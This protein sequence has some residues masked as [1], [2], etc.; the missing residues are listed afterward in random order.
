MRTILALLCAVVFASATQAASYTTPSYTLSA[1]VAANPLTYSAVT[2]T[3]VHN[4]AAPT[5]VAAGGQMTDPDF[6]T[7]FLRLTS[8]TS[9]AAAGGS[10]FMPNEGTGWTPTT[11]TNDTAILF[12]SSNGWWYVQ[13][14]T[15]NGSAMALNGACVQIPI[16]SGNTALYFSATNP[17]LIFGIHGNYFASY[18]WQTGV[19]TN[20]FDVATIP[21]F[22]VHSLYL[23][24]CDHADTWC[25]TS[26]NSQNAGT[27][28]AFY[29]LKT[30]ATAVYDL[31]AATVQLGSAT[32]VSMIGWTATDGA[33]CGIHET[34]PDPTGAYWDITLDT[35]TN[36]KSPWDSLFL[37]VGT[38]NM[39]YIK[40]TDEVGGHEAMGVGPVYVNMPGTSEGV[41]NCSPY[42]WSMNLWNVT[43]VGGGV[44]AGNWVGVSSCNSVWNA[45]TNAETGADETHMS[46]INNYP[47]AGANQYP[48]MVAFL[49]GTTAERWAYDDE[50]TCFR[51][52]RPIQSC[53][54][55]DHIGIGRRHRRRRSGASAICSTPT[56]VSITSAR[57]SRPMAC[58][59][60]S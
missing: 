14:V 58:T 44:N 51:C 24:F 8:A 59:R 12:A 55:V 6:G 28:L 48:I 52:R 11:N 3:L 57:M 4:S 26:N 34:I 45:V 15:L 36:H 9:C 1:G 39:F 22:T 7:R 2:D 37:Q 27:Q 17:A 41:A 10:S 60:P 20:I 38:A 5:L 43:N 30:G 56:R 21:G 16:S 31:A 23:A 53:K 18:N 40:D 13:P 25:A 33:G 19:T 49:E 35:C 50:L 54:L 29:N 32:P 42:Q 47:D 46:W